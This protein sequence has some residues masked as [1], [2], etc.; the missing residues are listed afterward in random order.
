[1]T[2]K[3]RITK[4][5]ERDLISAADY[6]EY[7]LKNPQAANEL[8]SK[9]TELILGLSDFPQRYEIV[10][11]PILRGWEI[12]FIRINNY[13]AFY[14][15]SEKDKMVYIVRFLYGKRDWLSILQGGII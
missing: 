4:A 1:M 12:R 6:I 2:Y 5:A 14:T 11:D 9:A 3:I 15:V 13:L 8:L 7:N 10:N